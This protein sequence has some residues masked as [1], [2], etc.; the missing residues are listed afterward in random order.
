MKNKGQQRPSISSGILFNIVDTRGTI[1]VFHTAP[2]GI[3]YVLGAFDLRDQTSL[4]ALPGATVPASPPG[5]FALLLSALAVLLQL[6]APPVPCALH[7][8]TKTCT[9]ISRHDIPL[10]RCASA[11]SS[12]ISTASLGRKRKMW[13]VLGGGGGRAAEAA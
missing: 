11:A 13:R 8:A 7:P 5:T 6:R 2:F 10:P 9:N 12:R 3:V 4:W 1:D